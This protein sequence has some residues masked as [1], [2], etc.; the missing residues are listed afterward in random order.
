MLNYV[1]EKYTKDINNLIK[2]LDDQVIDYL[3]KNR[4]ITLHLLSDLIEFRTNITLNNLVTAEI[5]D[6]GIYLEQENFIFKLGDKIDD[7]KYCSDDNSYYI[8]LNKVEMF[9]DF[10]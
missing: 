4:I 8:K 3:G 7:I 1:R 10:V 6:D 9:L 2:K 5:M